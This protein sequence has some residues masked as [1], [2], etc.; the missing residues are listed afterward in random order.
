MAVAND[1]SVL[2]STVGI[3][4]IPTERSRSTRRTLE[5]NESGARR[6]WSVRRLTASY[7]TDEPLSN[8]LAMRGIGAQV[9]P[10]FPSRA[11]Q[12][13]VLRISTRS[14]HAPVEAGYFHSEQFE[15]SVRGESGANET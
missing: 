11:L 12:F 1:R 13:A 10:A 7:P 15:R 5:R 2:W 6:G 14:R 3:G 9:D 8:W 4:R